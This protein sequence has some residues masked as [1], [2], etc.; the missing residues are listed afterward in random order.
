MKLKTLFS[1][2]TLFFLLA[3]VST[4]QVVNNTFGSVKGWKGTCKV[5]IVDSTADARTEYTF[6]GPATLRNEIDISPYNTSWP[7]PSMTPG[8][9][10]TGDLQQMVNT[11]KAQDDK[12]RVWKALVKVKRQVNYNDGMSNANYTCIFNQTQLRKLQIAIV[13][14]TVNIVPEVVFSDKL[15]CTGTRDDVAVL[16]QEEHQLML[17]KL[18]VKSNAPTSGGKRLNGIKRF[19]ED[20]KRIVVQ[21]D[22]SPVE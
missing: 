20:S 2:A 18:E 21:W 15:N 5:F 3:E 13:G 19:T 16:P 12:W 17:N 22:F 14:N 8:V 10:N 11:S 4:E 1:T 9:T 7:S 6:E